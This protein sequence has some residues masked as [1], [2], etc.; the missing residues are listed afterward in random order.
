MDA[1]TVIASSVPIA[2]VYKMDDWQKKILSRAEFGHYTTSSNDEL[3]D[4]LQ[5][6]DKALRTEIAY[7]MDVCSRHEERIRELE[8]ELDEANKKLIDFMVEMGKAIL[9]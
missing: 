7:R 5:E 8:R 6:H 4:M 3:Y 2:P 9:K 1:R